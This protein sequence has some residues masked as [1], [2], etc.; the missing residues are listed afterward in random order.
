MSLKNSIG[1][2]SARGWRACRSVAAL[3]SVAVLVACPAVAATAGQ[4][5]AG[6]PPRVERDAQVAPGEA[7]ASAHPIAT[8]IG[9]E[10]LE[11]GGNAFDAAVAVSAALAVVEPF[12]SGFGGGG[13]WLLHRAA[14]RFETVVDG[15]ELAPGSA[16][17]DRYLDANGRPIPKATLDGP[18]AAG[19]PGTPAALDLIA[20]RYGT[21][22]LRKL[23]AP[24][25]DVARAGFAVDLRYV[26]L[27]RMRVDALRRLSG[28]AVPF[29]DD[30]E[31]PRAGYRL[32][33]SQL[34][35][36][37]E[38]FGRGGAP[39]YYRGRTGAELVR[40]VRAAGGLWQQKDLDGYRAVER[41][42]VK[43]SLSSGATVTTVPPPS[44]AGP[45]LAQSLQIVDE[46]GY[47]EAPPVERM[48]L[49]VEALRRAFY[50]RARY[51]GD[52]DLVTA[53]L[54]R[55]E[56]R[57]YARQRALTID[58]AR[59]TT[60]ASVLAM[61]RLEGENTTHLSIVDRWGNRVAATMS[62]NTPFGSGF[63]AGNT[64]VVLNNE[65][66][67]FALVANDANF[68]GLGSSGPN[69]LGPGRRPLSSMSP[70]FVED[71]RGVLVLGTPGGSRI[72]SMVALG[73]LAYL[74]DPRPD[75]ERIVAL[76]RFHHQFAPDKIEVE[77]DGFPAPVLEALRQMGHTVETGK[78]KWGNMQ[79]VFWDRATGQASAASDPRG[80]GGP[81]WY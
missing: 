64:G 77:P 81:A 51:L 11:H 53:P 21:I 78:R 3:A 1:S 2:R 9:Y 24:A 46:L 55:L 40:A 79:A 33:Q 7:V 25:V 8:A 4:A 48:H 16:T 63:V 47:R 29:L 65:M 10:I 31:V 76:P 36:T 62:I 57:E 6:T 41:R 13:F 37:I 14:D 22:P 17:L 27:A 32:V 80:I 75:P 67:D 15:R 30:G 12:S 68:Y 28:V 20:R 56:G 58:R 59:A 45:T 5:R 52:P 38:A 44:A 73:V 66:D 69:L 60:D 72:L 19:I 26:A 49:L 42:P 70:S 54:A 61:P 35:D 74:D 18:L 43:F 23:V 50:D 34:A 71:A 39:A